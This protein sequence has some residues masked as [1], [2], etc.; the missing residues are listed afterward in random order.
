MSYN[1]FLGAMAVPSSA[2][3]PINYWDPEG[4]HFR[5]G[6][7]NGWFHVDCKRLLDEMPGHEALRFL[8][9]Q[10]WTRELKKSG[11]RTTW[12]VLDQA[13]LD[14]AA[15][16]LD[17][18]LTRCGDH[19]ELLTVLFAGGGWTASDIRAALAFARDLQGLTK[20]V[21]DGGEDDSPKFLFSVLFNLR[22]L[23][24][25]AQEQQLKLVYY[26]WLPE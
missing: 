16:Q 13:A 18:L 12:S 8:A 19:T 22:T 23:V 25:L 7:R 9:A 6:S 10:A 14:E 26:N 11:S 17:N 4:P 20:D 3:D 15:T 5:A 1:T 21:T 2:A 24:R